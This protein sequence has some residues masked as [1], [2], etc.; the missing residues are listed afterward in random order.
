MVDIHTTFPSFKV[1]S[2][3]LTAAGIPKPDHPPHPCY[4]IV[5]S[6]YWA[7][8][9]CTHFT[10]MVLTYKLPIHSHT[11][12][13]PTPSH[14]YALTIGAKLIDKS[15]TDTIQH[16]YH[17]HINHGLGR[18]VVTGW[19]ARYAPTTYKPV[20]TF[21]E[22]GITRPLLLNTA[23][24]HS[25]ALRCDSGYLE[26]HIKSLTTN[27]LLPPG[28][29]EINACPFCTENPENLKGNSPHLH[30]ECTHP[31]IVTTRNHAA[32]ILQNAILPFRTQD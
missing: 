24:S 20:H 25:R 2:H 14:K 3:Q 30:I 21:P 31:H 13:N 1:K 11:P 28:N 18:R 27:P 5:H 10:E 8:I 17:N 32:E 9:I 7:D 22:R 29:K 12:T 23:V 4:S 6:N 26:R 19:C 15:T 16:Q